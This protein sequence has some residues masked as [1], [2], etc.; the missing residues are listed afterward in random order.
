[1]HNCVIVKSIRSCSTRH[2]NILQNG[3]R[4]VVSDVISGQNRLSLVIV[5]Q[6]IFELLKSLIL[7]RRRRS[8]RPI[9]LGPNQVGWLG[10]L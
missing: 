9:P 7:P 1:M 2:S 5:A 3:Q 6:I 10:R 8:T 4:E